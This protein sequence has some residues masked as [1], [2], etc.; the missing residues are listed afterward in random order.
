MAAQVYVGPF[1]VNDEEVL[2]RL[3]TRHLVVGFQF[4][5]PEIGEIARVAV[6]VKVRCD[7]RIHAH[8]LKH[9]LVWRS[10]VD[11]ALLIWV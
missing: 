2:L 9:R 5:Q 7:D 8:G 10:P 1:P 4:A 11:E 6:A 3:P